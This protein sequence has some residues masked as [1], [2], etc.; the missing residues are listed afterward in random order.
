MNNLVVIGFYV[1]LS[2][3]PHQALYPVR[4]SRASSKYKNRRNL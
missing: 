3:G 1:A 2:K 4:P